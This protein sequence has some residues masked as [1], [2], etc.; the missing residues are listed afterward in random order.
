MDG[1]SAN[2]VIVLVIYSSVVRL[3]QLIAVIS[4]SPNITF[5]FDPGTRSWMLG[6]VSADPCATLLF[7]E[8]VMLRASRLTNTRSAM[9]RFIR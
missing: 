8:I 1:D 6:A 3:T 9:V 4:T 7:L 2:F 5:R